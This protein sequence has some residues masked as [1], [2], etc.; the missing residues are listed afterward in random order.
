VTLRQLETASHVERPAQSFGVP[1][2]Y[3][4]KKIFQ[5]GGLHSNWKAAAQPAQLKYQCKMKQRVKSQRQRRGWEWWR[6]LAAPAG[7]QRPA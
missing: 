2:P 5:S 4:W 1:P 6:H 3:R 7:V